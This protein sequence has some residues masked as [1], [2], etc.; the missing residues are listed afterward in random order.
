M[1]QY[2]VAA[3]HGYAI[4][5]LPDHGNAALRESCLAA[6]PFCHNAMFRHQWNNIMPHY[7]MTVLWQYRMACTF[8]QT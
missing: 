1:L 5:E 8:D 3:L 2:R 6:L 4:V 7:R